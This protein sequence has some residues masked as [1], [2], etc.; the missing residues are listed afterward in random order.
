MKKHHYFPSKA[1]LSEVLQAALYWQATDYCEETR[2][3]MRSLIA[4]KNFDELRA[5]LCTRIE[6]GTAGLRGTMQAGYSRMNYVTVQQT[7]QGLSA[8]LLDQFSNEEC[9]KHG[10]VIGYDARHNSFGFAHVAAAV[11]RLNGIRV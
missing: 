4:S 6:F 10:V 1:S 2:N 11:F 8:Y 7:T 3:E 9:E 5:R